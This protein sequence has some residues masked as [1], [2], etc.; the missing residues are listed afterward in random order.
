MV[1][2][3]L[4]NTARY[5]VKADNVIDQ[6]LRHV[7]GNFG[8]FGCSKSEPTIIRCSTHAGL[9]KTA[10]IDSIG[11]VYTGIQQAYQ[12]HYF[13]QDKTSI[14]ARICVLNT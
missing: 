9:S 13:H 2:I 10:S 14:P 7:E 12:D 1:V 5:L 8:V 11:L 4:M 6:N 3:V